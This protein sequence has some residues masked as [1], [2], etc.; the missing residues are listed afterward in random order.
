M[1]PYKSPEYTQHGRI[2]KKTD[3]VWCFG[4]LILK[5]LTGR[6]P[7]TR[8]GH[9]RGARPSDVGMACCESDVEKRWDLKE[10]VERVEEVKVMSD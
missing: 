1:I 9:G 8:E 4:I 7:A 6:F 3:D 2:T 10:A 5:T